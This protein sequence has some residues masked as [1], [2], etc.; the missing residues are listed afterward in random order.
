MAGRFVKHGNGYRLVQSYR[1][2]GKP[3]VRALMSVG[4]DPLEFLKDDKI[5]EVE[6]TRPDIAE[7]LRQ[8]KKKRFPSLLANDKTCQLISKDLKEVNVLPFNI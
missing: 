1:E 7:K 8:I 2:N 6:K 3:K 4:K 5:A